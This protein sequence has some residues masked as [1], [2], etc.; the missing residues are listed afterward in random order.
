MQMKSIILML[1]I[2]DEY[3]TRALWKKLLEEK[4]YKVEEARDG[5]KGYKMLKEIKPDL[6]I[7]DLCM[8]PRGIDT[9]KNLLEK[10][11]KNMNIMEIPVII[12]SGVYSN[13]DLKNYKDRFLDVKEVFQKPISDEDLIK[14]IQKCC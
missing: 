2:E 6:V 12:I 10:K 4:G 5:M 14:A 13:D 11:S 8:E 9:G 7:L 1:I 3:T